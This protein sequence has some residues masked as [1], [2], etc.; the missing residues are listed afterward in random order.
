MAVADLLD[1]VLGQIPDAPVRVLGSSEHA[2]GV[3]PGPEPGH[4][5][6]L[7]VRADGIEG[8]VPGRPTALS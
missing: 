7:I 8:L 2:L 5:P 3:E 6:R 4:V 1:E